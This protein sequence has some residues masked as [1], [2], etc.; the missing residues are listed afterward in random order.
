MEGYLVM[1]A[2]V[3][4]QMKAPPS[5]IFLQAGVGGLAA[6]CAAYFR[7]AW[8]DTPQI[9]VA[10]PDAAAALHD[11]IKEGPFAAQLPLTF[12]STLF[13]NTV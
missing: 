6:A 11:A 13:Y 7:H 12:L 9:L 2:E 10:E 4:H 8:G 5:H 1:A 3:V